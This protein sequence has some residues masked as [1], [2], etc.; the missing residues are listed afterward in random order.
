MHTSFIYKPIHL[1]PASAPP[2]QLQRGLV[3]P[4]MPH[5]ESATARFGGDAAVSVAMAARFG[6]AAAVSAVAARFTGTVAHFFWL[7]RL[8]VI[9]AAAVPKRMPFIAV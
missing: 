9:E 8:R 3:L 7:T 2:P 5:V 4:H 6:G 1:A